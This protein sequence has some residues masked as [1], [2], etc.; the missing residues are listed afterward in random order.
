VTDP[1]GASARHL[2]GLHHAPL[3]GIMVASMQ[4]IIVSLLNVPPHAS[5]VAAICIGSFV[6]WSLI[7]H[8]SL[9]TVSPAR[10]A[11]V[12]GGSE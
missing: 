2:N 12:R 6:T 9:S 5:S 8:G 11:V 3:V 10:L 7:V 4:S 1:I